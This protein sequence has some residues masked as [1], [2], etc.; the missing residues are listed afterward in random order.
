M[1]ANKR[2]EVRYSIGTTFYIKTGGRKPTHSALPPTHLAEMGEPV[3]CDDSRTRV[4]VTH[5]HYTVLWILF[6]PHS[7]SDLPTWSIQ[8]IPPT[9]APAWCLPLRYCKV[10]QVSKQCIAVSELHHTA[11]ENH[12]PCGI[13]QCYQ[14]PGSGD[15][16]AF[17]PAEAGTRLSDP[18]GVQGWVGLGGGYNSEESLTA[19]DGHLS[20]K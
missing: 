3:K 7:D 2:R 12:I 20:Q 14:P 4:L 5:A 13:T 1:T 16:P 9:C 8:A 19:K 11:T 15:F 10:S 18:G 6:D 17:T